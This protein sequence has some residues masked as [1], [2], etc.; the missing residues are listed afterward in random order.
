[1]YRLYRDFGIVVIVLIPLIA[2]LLTIEHPFTIFI[3]MVLALPLG[4]SL[5]GILGIFLADAESLLRNRILIHRSIDRQSPPGIMHQ[6]ARGRDQS[7]IV[8]GL[9]VRMK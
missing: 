5:G 2:H 3:S 7:S 6:Q 4:I 8:R 1:M 9:P